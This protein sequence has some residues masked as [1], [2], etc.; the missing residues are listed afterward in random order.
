MKSIF[1]VSLALSVICF[2]ILQMITA[3]LSPL[4]DRLLVQTEGVTTPGIIHT[5]D[6][7]RNADRNIT[8]CTVYSTIANANISTFRENL[9]GYTVYEVDGAYA[10]FMDIK[11][12][13]GR[14]IFDSDV[15][16][17]SMP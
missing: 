6:E 12:I 8:G 10:G 3:S 5:L 2:I 1:R 7:Y 17:G 13:K 16:K 9:S 15:R 4:R 11:M 14:F